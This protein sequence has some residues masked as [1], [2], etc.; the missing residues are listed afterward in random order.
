MYR[1]TTEAKQYPPRLRSIFVLWLSFLVRCICLSVCIREERRKTE[2]GSKGR[3]NVTT[4][5]VQVYI[6]RLFVQGQLKYFNVESRV[7]L[8]PFHHS[9][10]A[11]YTH[12]HTN[13]NRSVCNQVKALRPHLRKRY[14]YVD[15][16]N[17]PTYTQRPF[18]SSIFLCR[19][20][21]TWYYTYGTWN[22]FAKLNRRCGNRLCVSLCCLSLC[23]CNEG[24]Y[25]ANTFVH[26][27]NTPICTH[28]LYRN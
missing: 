6:L 15:I 12:T 13:T 20:T 22:V 14:T 16:Y 26:V 18:V 17:I 3:T 28:A 11:S 7:Y 27:N 23:T 8:S 25:V 1:Y 19:A 24:I 10:I 9:S 21:D 5:A 4:P 2:R